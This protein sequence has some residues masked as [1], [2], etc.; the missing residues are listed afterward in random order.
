M[1]LTLEE[2]RKRN[3]QLDGLRGYAALA[4]VFW[5]SMLAADRASVAKIKSTPLTQLS[6]LPDIAAK[7]ALSI[8]N[9]EAAVI[10]FFVL[11]G[12]VLVNSLQREQGSVVEISWR[13]AVRRVFRIYPALLLAIIV[14]APVFAII[15]PVP[16][17]DVLENL[18]LYDWKIVGPSWTLHVELVAMLFILPVFF[19]YRRFGEAGMVAMIVAVIVAINS[20]YFKTSLLYSKPYVFAFAAGM[21]VPSRIGA[22]VAAKTPVWIWPLALIVAMFARNTVPIGLRTFLIVEAVAAGIVVTLL[23]YRRA[24]IFGRFLE[25]PSSIFLGRISF[26]LYLLNVPFMIPLEHFAPFPHPVLTGLGYGALVA[27]I[28]VPFAYWSMT[29]VETPGIALGPRLT[30]SKAEP[31]PQQR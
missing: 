22:F 3:D 25:R 21:L 31:A 2:R 30:A 26:S 7:L 8:V 14:T 27:L 9:G 4:V 6:G 28:V 20:P 15:A 1:A 16:L 24:G 17:R 29:Y 12:A 13:F 10:L 19:A 11:S 23:Y 5:H 18:I